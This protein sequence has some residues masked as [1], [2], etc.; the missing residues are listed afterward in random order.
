MRSSELCY[1][2]EK[3]DSMRSSE[4]GYVT[5]KTNSMRL[6]DLTMMRKLSNRTR[7]ELDPDH[8][9]ASLEKFI[10]R[11]SSHNKTYGIEDADWSLNPTKTFES[12]T[13]KMDT[14]SSSGPTTMR[15][16]SNRTKLEP[17]HRMASL[18][19]FMY[20]ISSHNKTYGIEDADWSL[21]PTKTFGSGDGPLTNLATAKR[22]RKGEKKILL[23]HQREPTT[24]VPPLGRGTRGGWECRRKVPRRSSPE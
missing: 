1:V 15:K 4:L 6:S 10:Y 12:V 13:G 17:D 5:G 8:R 3:T 2:T 16:L 7:L 23:T 21:N 9:V 22:G 24:R 11:I 19:K 14:M 18:E 20:R